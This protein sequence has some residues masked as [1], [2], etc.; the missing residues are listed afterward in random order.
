MQENVAWATALIEESLTLFRHVGDTYGIGWA[1]NH[2][3]H[4]A[5]LQGDY[6][7]ATRL[8]EE[9]LPLFR[10]YGAPDLGVAQALQSLGETALAQGDAALATTH[11][12]EALMLCRDLGDRAGMAWCLAGLAGVAAVNEDPERAAWLWGAAE[13]LRQSIGAREAP[14]SRATRERL[15]AQARKQLGEAAFAAKWAEGQKMTMEEAIA[16]ALGGEA[17]REP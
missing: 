13:A 2:L 8:H 4:V 17:A 10:E 5:Q 16:E 14:A 12:T 3:G 11:F 15:I 1:L 9:S 6:G 7:R